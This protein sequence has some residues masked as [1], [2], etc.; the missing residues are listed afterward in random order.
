[1]FADCGIHFPG[2]YVTGMGAELRFNFFEDHFNALR[3]SP[4]IIVSRGDIPLTSSSA[5]IVN[6]SQDF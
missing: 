5:F 3:Q 6:A 2:G 4:R 1:M